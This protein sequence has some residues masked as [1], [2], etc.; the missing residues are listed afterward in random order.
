MK[1][2]HFFLITV[3]LLLTLNA[4]TQTVYYPA[5]ASKLLQTSAADMAMLLQKAVKGS[6]FT[7]QSYTSLPTSGIVLIYDSITSGNQYCK[8]TSNGNEY[9]SFA[10]PQ[11]N[12]LNFGI[13]QYLNQIGF[14]FYQPG[15]IWEITPSLNT[16]FKKIDTTYSCQ[17]K[18][19]NWFISGGHN[20]WAMDND[21]SYYWESYFGENGHQWSLYQRRNNMTGG[22]RFTGHRDDIMTPEYLIELQTSP[23]YVAPYNDSRIATLQ[24]VPD[25]NS[26]TA[27]QVWANN[28]E[29]KYTSYKNTIY[30]NT[31]IYANYF[32]NFN[33]NNEYIGIE[34]PDGAHWANTTDNNGCGTK[35]LLKASD[36]HF[37]LANHVANSIS[38]SYP[39]KRFQLYAYD[40]HAD[41]PSST[42]AI[43]N[44]IDIQVV[45]T[46]F[47]N[48]TSA[49]GLLNRWYGKTSNI[50]EYHYLNLGQ[51]SGETPSFYLDELKSTLQRLKEKNSQGIVWEAS[52]AKFA[53]LPFL[54]AANAQLKDNIQV[55]S[56]LHEF[57]NSL[58]GT[59]S[60]TIF[61]LLQQW[62]NDKTVTVSNG[63]QDN[64]YKMPLYFQLVKD[65]VNQTQN[66]PL[67]V[68]ER[69]NEL[70]A[71]LH[72]MGLYY[73]WAFD[74]R[75]YAAKANKA[76]A[77]C[78]YLAKI[79]R[80]QIVN[81][82]FLISDIV[83]KYA[84]AD[85][86]FT[87]YNV[88]NG[89]AYLNGTLPLI[90]ATEINNNFSADYNIQVNLINEYSFK[91]VSEIKA[92][93]ENNNMSPLEKIDLF[94]NYTNGKDY[95]SRS[96]MF[97]SADKA[98]S[99]QIKYT[100][101]FNMSGNGYINFTVE[102][103]DKSLTVIK[104]FSVDR[105]G[106]AGILFVPITVAGN[107]KLTVT[108][109]YKSAVKLTIIS[110]GNYFY[111]NGPFLGNTIE[112]YRS[113][114][115]SLPGYFY[116]PSGINKVF[117]SIN[118]SNPAGNGFATAAEIGAS[119]LFKDNNNNAVTPKLVNNSDSALFY[120]EVPA[121]S[122]GHFWQ[123]FKMEQY[124]LCF[125]NIS[126]IQWYA[127]IKACNN[128]DFKISVEKKAGECITQLSSNTIGGKLKWQVYDGGQ[129]YQFNN[130]SVVELPNTIS[131]NAIVTLSNGNGCATS[132][133]LGD[134]A[135]YLKSIASC[136]NEG[137]L[138]TAT[139]SVTVFPNPGVGIF[140]CQQNGGPVLASA[141]EIYNLAGFKVAAFSNTQQFNI[142][143]LPAG[144]YFYKLVIENK[145]F[146][147]K[148]IKA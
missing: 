18:Y 85:S 120:L 66:D 5:T 32:R 24:S 12:G 136:A 143:H 122:D 67:I 101:Q 15:S 30:N 34:V 55:D 102:S 9:I 64:K 128:A 80:L 92:A 116:V 37:T 26:V 40:S 121:G 93:F 107:Y 17:Y 6:Q 65:A 131:P 72:Y 108:T 117:F 23:C 8:V 49:K 11:D 10:A 46:A 7:T 31:A 75:S 2:I 96:E 97:I 63:I 82:F 70:K 125:A 78:I 144:I 81:S 61:K 68:K 25:V 119:F 137:A 44:L 59:A 147:G 115:L 127:S 77:L 3:C 29:K 130:Q 98:G 133:R 113:N 88:D 112:N 20:T 91:E 104:D 51:W 111:R 33:Y 132:K 114:L 99:F 36:Q 105:N 52:P 76:A 41:I 129:S 58:F 109:K 95:T 106:T 146:N 57:C 1:T 124:R 145:Y 135:V 62:S 45:A 139:V 28:I 60:S 83:N 123:A 16:A 118:N 35:T 54:L 47:Q 42:I 4:T 21:N 110:N 90:T 50:S 43:N 138:A 103:T 69:L 148:V 100:P 39:N 84:T 13:Y 134:D 14:R 38:K 86:I 142:T 56:S 94:I 89:T 27:M 71:Y 53:S 48:E 74:Q 22:N 141:I 140:K 126:N 73:D 19:K 79:N 87:R